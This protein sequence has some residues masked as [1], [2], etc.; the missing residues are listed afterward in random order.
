[1]TQTE[2]TETPGGPRRGRPVKGSE[3]S[4][5]KAL[6][7]A[8]E[9]VFLEK[10]LAASMDDIAKR[11]GVSK[12][13]IY[14]CTATKETLFADVIHARIENS[15]LSHLP[16]TVADAHAIEE[17]MVQF[18]VQLAR[19]VLSPGSVRLYRAV[20]AEATRFPELARTYYNEGP[21]YV[22][23]TLGTWLAARV[24]EG[25]LTIDDPNEAAAILGGA[26]IAAPLRNLTLGIVGAGTEAAIER[27]ARTAV[28]YFL[29]GA[30]A[31]R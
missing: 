6:L 21:A 28:H 5:R 16:D 29:K 12:K 23:T 22:I 7:A 31:K 11:A 18:F 10:G 17:A 3:E 9:E 15:Q 4:R 2:I 30:L 19:F 25:W 26:T 13:T 14:S 8:A 24:R 20:T 1:M 27:R